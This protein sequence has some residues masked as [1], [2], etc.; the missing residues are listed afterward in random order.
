[1]AVFQSSIPYDVLTPKPLPGIAPLDPRAWLIV[2]EAYGGQMARRVAL[3]AQQRDEVIQLDPSAR[4]AAIEL[5]DTVLSDLQ[6][7]EEF[8]VTDTLVACPDGR[9]VNIRRDDPLGTLGRLVQ[10]DFCILQKP[11]DAA[12]HIMTGAVLCFP[13]NWRLADK[14]MHP[15]T[16]IHVPVGEYSPEIAK[17]VQRLFDGI[18]VG[19]P[20]WRNNALWYTDADLFQPAKGGNPKPVDGGTGPYMRSERQ[21]LIRLP[22]SGAVVFGI[23][24]FLVRAEDLVNPSA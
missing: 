22:L 10:D 11:A 6:G 3:I 17:R 21:T 16:H 9:S 5:L 2:D 12:E 13:A 1:M 15:L 24:T 7:R 18:Q 8:G 23:H 14:F 4:D 19:R 20:L